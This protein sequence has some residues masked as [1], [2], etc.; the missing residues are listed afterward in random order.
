MPKGVIDV[1]LNGVND[2]DGC[3]SCPRLR[4]VEMINVPQFFFISR[5]MM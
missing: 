4:D 3:S 2:I 1:V 5:L